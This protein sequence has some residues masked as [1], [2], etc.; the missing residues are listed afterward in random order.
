M[1]L[2]ITIFPLHP[3]ILY[4]TSLFEQLVQA[5][6]QAP[7]QILTNAIEQ[8]L[9]LAL[10]D[11]LCFGRHVLARAQRRVRL[12]GLLHKRFYYTDSILFLREGRQGPAGES[13]GRSAARGR[14]TQTCRGQ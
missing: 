3:Y 8:D 12:A 5:E 2:A 7:A 9:V 4:T 13:G 1:L 11:V 6:G 10:E 14:L